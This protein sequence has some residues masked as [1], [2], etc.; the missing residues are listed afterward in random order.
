M[1]RPHSPDDPGPAWEPDEHHQ[2]ALITT[3]SLPGTVP[4]PGYYWQAMSYGPT[5]DMLSGALSHEEWR[6]D[7]D[8]AN[9][10]SA[11]EYAFG[12]AVP[13]REL[14]PSVIDSDHR[15]R[16]RA[17]LT[18]T[19][20]ARES[21]DP[22][23]HSRQASQQRARAALR[24]VEFYTPDDILRPGPPTP[25]GWSA[26]SST[27]S[28]VRSSSSDAGSITS[29]VARQRTSDLQGH[30]LRRK[31]AFGATPGAE[32]ITS[33][34]RRSAGQSESPSGKPYDMGQRGPKPG[35]RGAPSR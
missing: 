27:D 8:Y 11:T 26:P 12:A 35:R 13:I 25:D 28:D 22:H 17:A 16:A 4:P 24:Q 30:T 23:R 31:N 32:S 15:R 20:Q 1:T 9:R 6:R 2:E 7:Y 21:R 29:D 3:H 5:A 33:L 10:P 34:G 18:E 14:D 19:S